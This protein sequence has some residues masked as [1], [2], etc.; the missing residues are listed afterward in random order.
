MLTG[1]IYYPIVFNE[2]ETETLTHTH[3]YSQGFKCLK[4]TY[5]GFEGVSQL[6]PTVFTSPSLSVW[7]HNIRD[8]ADSAELIC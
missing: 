7:E 4:W 2:T 8:S 5:M 3:R 6:I 1:H